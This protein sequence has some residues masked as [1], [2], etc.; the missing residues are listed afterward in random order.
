M[1]KGSP[2]VG[3]SCLEDRTALIIAVNIMGNK[4]RTEMS[5]G[6]HR[7]SHRFVLGKDK[8]YAADKNITTGSTCVGGDSHSLYPALMLNALRIHLNTQI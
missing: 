7:N 1:T 5:F 2:L 4:S 8:F 3:V 6:T